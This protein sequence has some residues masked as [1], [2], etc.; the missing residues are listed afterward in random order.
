MKHGVANAGSSIRGSKVKRS[1][2]ETE[3]AHG[4]RVL[5]EGVIMSSCPGHWATAAG[6]PPSGPGRCCVT[7]SRALDGSAE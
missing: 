1:G 3:P 4:R 7:I 2:S 5:R 6:L